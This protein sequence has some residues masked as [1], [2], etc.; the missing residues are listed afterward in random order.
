MRKS[1]LSWSM[2]VRETTALSKS[3]RSSRRSNNRSIVTRAFS[4]CAH[5]ARAES[6]CHLHERLRRV[7]VVVVDGRRDWRRFGRGL[8]V[9]VAVQ[10]HFFEEFRGDFGGILAL[11][12][13]TASEEW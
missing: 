2:L 6:P 1:R 7:F 9:A 12:I 5:L 4:P 8:T 11:G 10:A 13:A 3:C